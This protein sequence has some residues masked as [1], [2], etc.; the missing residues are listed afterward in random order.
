MK[1]EYLYRSGPIIL[2]SHALTTKRK[3]TK[4]EWNIFPTKIHTRIKK[5]DHKCNFLM[6]TA[7]PC[8]YIITLEQQFF[9]L[10]RHV[11][12]RRRARRANRRIDSPT[13]R[14]V[15]GF[16]PYTILHP[17]F[18]YRSPSRLLWLPFSLYFTRHLPL[19][20]H[21]TFIYTER[22]S[23]RSI[24]ILKWYLGNL[25]MLNKYNERNTFM[26]LVLCHVMASD[27]Y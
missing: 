26:A 1:A 27:V 4:R 15:W 11:A 9:T 6:S 7:A 25:S 16:C 3:S 17:Y 10:S 2:P 14:T 18:W 21:I 12:L 13:N 20:T 24:T 8:M 5:K 23:S 19:S 22:L